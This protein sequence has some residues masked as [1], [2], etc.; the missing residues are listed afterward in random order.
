MRDTSLLRSG[1]IV[2]LGVAALLAVAPAHAESQSS[3]TSTNCSNGYCTRLET[4]TIEDRYGRRGWQWFDAW[5][6]PGYRQHHG[7]RPWWGHRQHQRPRWHRQNH[8][9]WD[10]DDD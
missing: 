3:N 6:E 1:L 10:D 9:G 7:Y 4:R 5:H 2:A 8:R